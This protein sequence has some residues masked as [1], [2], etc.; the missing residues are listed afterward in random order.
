MITKEKAI[1]ASRTDIEMY[2]NV[3]MQHHYHVSFWVL[4]IWTTK[5][6]SFSQFFRGVQLSRS[7]VQRKFDPPT[8][9]VACISISIYNRY[10]VH[11]TYIDHDIVESMHAFF[12]LQAQMYQMAM[13]ILHLMMLCQPKV[14]ML[15]VNYQ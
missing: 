2:K 3:P 9:H 6:C 13:L 12:V 10:L 11:N 8:P 4:V 5:E 7:I 1:Q 15:N 14:E